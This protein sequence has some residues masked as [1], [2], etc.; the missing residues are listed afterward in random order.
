MRI[1]WAFVVFA[2]IGTILLTWYLRTKNMDFLT[3]SGLEIVET[4]E[5]SDLI[6][7]SVVLQP[8]IK[9]QPKINRAIQQP[10]DP[11]KITP[12][13]VKEITEFELGDLVA[14]PGLDAYQNFARR[15]S[16]DRLFELS[17]ALR[18]RGEFQRALLAFERVI[19]TSEA[20]PNSRAEAAQG[21]AAL[22]KNLP[23]WNID[24]SNEI[25]LNL[26]LGM[27]QK[28]SDHLRDVL[29]EVATRIRGASGDQLNII[30]TIDSSD[31]SDSPTNNPIALWLSAS[32][33]N[34]TSSAVITIRLAKKNEEHL[35][36]ISLAVFK[37][38]RSHLIQ[39]GYPPASENLK[40]GEDYLSRQITRLM[41]RDFAQSLHSP[42]NNP[43]TAGEHPDESADLN[44]D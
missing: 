43:N 15:E 40:K 8:K 41:W 29:R 34:T 37:T 20:D 38:I 42:Q 26:H 4:E 24:P 28:P 9:D 17:S 36:E 44:L 19:D 25:I 3:P 21:I 13:K 5:T 1:H 16:P 7:L 33:D 11:D 18:A 32:G 12:P 30:P 10:K 35:E 6:D 31:N 27:A 39:F 2:V 22:T 23:N 14:S